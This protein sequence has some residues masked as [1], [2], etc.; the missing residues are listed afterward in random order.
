LQPSHRIGIAILQRSGKKKMLELYQEQRTKSKEQ[1][2]NHYLEQR[3]KSKEQRQNHY[4]EQGT[5]E[6]RAK[7]TD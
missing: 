6:Q 7:T 3:A 5:K 1:R 2:Q 4:L